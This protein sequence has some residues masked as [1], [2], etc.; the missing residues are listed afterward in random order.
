MT[1]FVVHRTFGSLQTLVNKEDGKETNRGGKIH[2]LLVLVDKYGSK[3]E[4]VNEEDDK[5][6]SVDAPY[7][8]YFC[9]IELE[10]RIRRR[11]NP[12][13]YHGSQEQNQP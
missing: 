13:A 3:Q 12:H 5:I 6:Y 9:P 2:Q 11:A 7:M 1:E 10:A 8:K 4:I